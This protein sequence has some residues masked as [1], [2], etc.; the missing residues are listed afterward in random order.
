ME[1]ITLRTEPIGIPGDCHGCKRMS[2]CVINQN[3]AGKAL[4]ERAGE[5][6]DERWPRGRPVT[7]DQAT[8]MGAT[9]EFYTLLNACNDQFELFVACYDNDGGEVE[10]SNGEEIFICGAERGI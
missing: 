10:Y 9:E 7:L 5:L 1:K 8:Q 3:R 4:V 6:S 2:N